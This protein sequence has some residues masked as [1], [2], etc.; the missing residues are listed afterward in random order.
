M[1]VVFI[2]SLSQLPSLPSV[3]DTS[4]H[5]QHHL[6]TGRVHI[7]HL[8]LVEEEDGE[9]EEEEEEKE[10]EEEEEMEEEAEEEEEE[11][12]EKEEEKEEEEEER[13]PMTSIWYTDMFQFSHRGNVVLVHTPLDSHPRPS[14][15]GGAG[16]ILHYPQHIGHL[17]DR[18]HQLL[19]LAQ[20]KVT[21]VLN[22]LS[23]EERVKALYCIPNM[24]MQLYCIAHIHVFTSVT[25]FLNLFDV[26]LLVGLHIDVSFEAL[27]CNGTLDL[28]W[29]MG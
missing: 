17:V 10:K 11:E 2:L 22:S 24:Y 28:K 9:E 19:P 15:Q 1:A 4:K 23:S 21:N 13:V 20:L 25:S 6:V 26:L 16:S 14:L 7:V 12:E 18:D 8:E 29:L 27:N 5:L 3:V